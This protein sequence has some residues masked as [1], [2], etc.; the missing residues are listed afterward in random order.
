MCRASACYTDLYWTDCGSD[1]GWKPI[2]GVV[3]TNA[4]AKFRDAERGARRSLRDKGFLSLDKL[5]GAN[6]HAAEGLTWNMIPFRGS[7]RLAV[8]TRAVPGSW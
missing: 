3:P 6:Q 8:G 1:A 7:G 5:N 2:L 4:L